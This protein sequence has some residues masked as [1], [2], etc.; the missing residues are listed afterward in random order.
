MFNP[1]TA[2]TTQ[3]RRRPAVGLLA[4]ITPP[5][6]VCST[7]KPRRLAGLLLAMTIVALATL[8]SSSPTAY[9][10]TSGVC[11]RTQHV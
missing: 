8:F 10:Q 9:A 6:K 3:S 11:D 5:P 4:L 2:K 7:M 1:V